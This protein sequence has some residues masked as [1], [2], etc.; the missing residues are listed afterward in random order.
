MQEMR[1][2]RLGWEDLLEEEMATPSSIL[3]WEISW[4]EEPG[5]LRSRGLQRVEHNWATEQQLI[6]PLSKSSSLEV[7][8][9]SSLMISSKPRQTSQF[10]FP[11]ST[12][13]FD[14]DTEPVP[15]WRPDSFPTLSPWW[16]HPGCRVTCN[17]SVLVGSPLTVGVCPGKTHN[18]LRLKETARFFP[19]DLWERDYYC[20]ASG[21]MAH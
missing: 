4:T 20:S 16:P 2:Q 15:P 17:L 8:T 5:R 3:V 7:S 14:I 9:S 19:G 13:L 18:S 11:A 12:H 10:F 1:A 21:N 6:I